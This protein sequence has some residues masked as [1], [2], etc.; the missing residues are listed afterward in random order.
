VALH[1][2]CCAAGPLVRLC[3]IVPGSVP[4]VTVKGPVAYEEVSQGHMAP[5]RRPDFDPRRDAVAAWALVEAPEP[6]F[7]GRQRA[8]RV[9][10][11]PGC[12]AAAPKLR[13]RRRPT[14]HLAD[15]DEDAHCR[16][17]GDR[18][19]DGQDASRVWEAVRR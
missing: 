4:Y 9:S 10:F 13:A 7:G 19:C 15:F 8:V 11:C 6:F 2:K 14:F 3:W 17:C 12:G 16:T 5:D 1:L 18:Y